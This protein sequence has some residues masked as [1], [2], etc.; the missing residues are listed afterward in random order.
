MECQVTD[1]ISSNQVI[2]VGVRKPKCFD[3]KD[4]SLNDWL[5]FIATEL[6]CLKEELEESS[7]DLVLNSNW[8]TSRLPIL[9]KKG[10]L[11]RLSGEVEG[12]NVS[13]T[14]CV[15]PFTPKHRWVVPIAHEFDPTDLT[16]FQVFIKVDVDRTVKLY[17]TG[18][19]PTGTSPKLYLDNVSFFIE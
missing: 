2:E 4:N 3:F 13:S 11:I 12:G 1:P 17:F 9:Y 19:A 15:L 8:T 14:I 6:C 10:N 5:K 16:D 7:Q 18:T